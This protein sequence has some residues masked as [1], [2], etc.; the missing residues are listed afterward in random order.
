MAKEDSFIF[1]GLV[2]R[3]NKEREIIIFGS[4]HAHSF[5]EVTKVFTLIE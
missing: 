3:N 4:S 1:N 2:S 5:N